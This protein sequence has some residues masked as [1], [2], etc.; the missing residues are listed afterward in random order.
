MSGLQPPFVNRGLA[1]RLS[2]PGKLARQLLM[3]S[4]CAATVVTGVW[5]MFDILRQNGTTLLEAALLLLFSITFSWIVI[6][7][8]SGAL[9]FVLQMLRIDPLSLRRRR[10]VDTERVGHLNSRTA[11]VMPV[12][13]EDTVRIMAGFEANLRSV[14][15][16]GQLGAFD[17]YLL[18]DTQDPTL[19]K[20]ELAGWQALLGRLGELAAHAF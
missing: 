20:A 6:A 19:I 16:T 7:F 5:L 12:Y 11:V 10:P 9:G 14:A 4:L 15:A 13:N 8:W 2:A 3:F 1:T 17:F 18:S